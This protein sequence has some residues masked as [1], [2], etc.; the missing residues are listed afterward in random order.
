MKN[1]SIHVLDGRLELLQPAEGFKTSIDAV[2][3]AAACPV[4]GGQSILDLGSGI[5]TAGLC[6]L[7]RVEGV[8]LT[9]V[10]IQDDHA[11]ISYENAVLNGFESRAEF[12]ASDIRA[13]SG[14]KYDHVIC[15]PPYLKAGSYVESTTPAKALAMGGDVMLGEWVAGAFDHI[16]GQGSFTIVHRADMI[17]QIIQAFGKRF[18]GIEIIP[19]WPRAGEAAK[20]VIVRGYKH[21]KSPAILHAGLA[22]HEDDGYSAAADRILR[23]MEG[24]YLG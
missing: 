8:S 10:E 12:I 9:G 4:R 6:V 23:G 1:K 7:A 24:L 11:R 14:R 15:N 20:R 2:L 3:L 22:L 16:A 19:L 5:G 18:G 17:E 21:K 13:F